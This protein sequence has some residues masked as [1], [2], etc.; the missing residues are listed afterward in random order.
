MVIRNGIAG[1]PGEVDV[2]I[3]GAGPAGLA[4]ALTCEALGRSVL[5]LEGGGRRPKR[6]AG[7][8]LDAIVE[9]SRHV[10]LHVGTRSGLGG[11]SWAWG[12]LC[13]P[14]GRTDM[15]GRPGIGI[16]GWP[17]PYAE[18]MRWTGPAA[19]FL[20][21]VD[22]DLASAEPENS[23][24]VMHSGSVGF[25]PRQPNMARRYEG[26]VRASRRI[27]CCLGV[28]VTGLRLSDDGRRAIGLTLAPSGQAKEAPGGRTDA[29]A[30]DLPRASAYILAC[31]GIETT[32][33]LL[34][35]RRRRPALF[36]GPD[37]PLGR[38]YMGHVA[39]HLATAVFRDVAGASPFLIRAVPGRGFRQ[40]R[41][42]IAPDAQHR[43]GLLNVAFTL[44]LPPYSDARHESGALS[45]IHLASHGPLGGRLR[46]SLKFQAAFPEEGGA[47][48]RGHVGNLLRHPVSTV[49][50]ATGILNP[51]RRHV[52]PLFPV[53][54]NRYTLRYHGEHAPD[55]DSRITLR[56]DAGG[57]GPCALNIDLRYAARDADSIVK[58]HD[59]LGAQLRDAG[60]ARLEYR[61]PPEER[62]EDVLAQA[63]DGYHQIGTT[64]MGADP[65]TSVVN[66][67]CRVHGMANVFVASS[68][69]FPTSGAC[70][71]T[72]TIVCLAIRLA[73]H[74]SGLLRSMASPP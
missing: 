46:R 32:R 14:M 60:I 69:T 27:H 40:R 64:R 44:R 52:P 63:K 3:V 1:A 50:G 54:G 30:Q 29:P 33:L 53:P 47:G 57:D 28:R 62:E 4:A 9:P 49:A 58:A 59:L 37:G 5:L 17:I 67:E 70:N 68:S 21:F 24:A 7:S 56:G 42:T 2:C 65:A 34:A 41:F 72:F 35:T 25:I 18:L 61:L 38:F 39:G 36:G 10:A 6:A 23:D 22:L 51:R 45:L 13:V 73:H 43:H 20:G 66:A 16:P 11:A 71:P 8:A 26:H 74:V 31:G 48:S 12:G 19:R 15:T 55:P